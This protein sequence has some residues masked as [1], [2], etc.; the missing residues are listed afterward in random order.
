VPQEGLRS[1]GPGVRRDDDN[2]QFTPH[3][4]FISASRAA[5]SS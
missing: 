5:E 2:L 1:M 3:L 4:S